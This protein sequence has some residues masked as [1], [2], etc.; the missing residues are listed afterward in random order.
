MWNN[1]FVVQHHPKKSTTNLKFRNK[2][3]NE[4]LLAHV[5]STKMEGRSCNLGFGLLEMIEFKF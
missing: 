2:Q 1:T 4:T 5:V 3:N